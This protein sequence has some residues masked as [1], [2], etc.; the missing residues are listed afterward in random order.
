MPYHKKTWLICFLA[1]ALTDSLARANQSCDVCV[2]GESASGVCAAIQAARMGK[3][4]I[5]ISQ[6]SH[7]GGMTTSG[8]TAT[9]INR[10]ALIDGIAR[11]FYRQLYAWYQTPEAWRNQEREA[12][13]V[14][15]LKRTFTGKNDP[16]KLQ[17]VYESHIGERIQLEM[18]HEAG[19]QLVFNERLD[20]QHGVR[21]RASSIVSIVMESGQ[22]F[23]ARIFID[24]SYTGDLMAAADVSYAVGRE[25][26]S[27]Y[28]E[29]HNG[30]QLNTVIGRDD[31]SVDPYVVEGDSRSGLLPN[32][33][34]R[35]WGKSG[36]SDPHR[37][38]TYCFRLTLT[39]DPTNR[40]SIERPENYDAAWYEVLARTLRMNPES[41]LQQ[42][43]TL[44]PMPNRKTD[45]NKLNF[46][47]VNYEYPEEDYATRARI[48]QLHRDFALGLLWFLGHDER[49]PEHI[50]TEMKPWGLPR[51][52]FLDNGHFPYQLYIREARR[53]VGQFVMTEE[54]CRLTEP[55]HVTDSIGVGTYMIDSHHFAMVLDEAGK[56]HYEG[57]LGERA[58]SYPISYRCITPKLEEC[59]NLLVPVCVSASHVAYS[60]IRME[61]VYM[62]LGQ[63]AG[64]AAALAIDGRC[65]VQQIAYAELEAKLL[66]AQQ[67]LRP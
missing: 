41:Q 31:N 67:I 54:N 10:H 46:V 28:D 58:A 5:L 51:D 35:L 17:W 15:S 4:V 66:E 1:F 38:Q 12:F 65:G 62:V 24:A 25:S 34:P 60:S 22:E 56:L 42:I 19:V 55:E 45:T 64:A 9:D 43:I 7:V 2:Y 63:S 49:V 39:D 23:S 6:N 14:S 59:D 47:G 16:L 57:G 21:K 3:Q 61:P 8:L 13:F 40:L 53:L 30:I 44:T 18:L 20:L 52:E 27:Q 50:R 26:N 29:S 37:I 36:D 32:I 33:E 11:E 48:D